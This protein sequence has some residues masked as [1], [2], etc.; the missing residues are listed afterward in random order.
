M[1]SRLVD[2]QLYSNWN[3]RKCNELSISINVNIIKTDIILS[4]SEFI[5]QQY[6]SS[7]AS[8][9]HATTIIV[10]GEF[11]VLVRIWKKKSKL[12]QCLRAKRVQIVFGFGC[13]VQPNSLS[14]LSL[15]LNRLSIE[16]QV[17]LSLNLLQFFLHRVGKTKSHFLTF[18][19]NM[20]FMGKGLIDTF[21]E[22]APKCTLIP[23]KWPCEHEFQ[24]QQFAKFVNSEMQQFIGVYS[25]GVGFSR[26]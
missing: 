3:N 6:T 22:I 1:E 18:V 13:A 9:T 21:F 4:S 20:I 8:N 19:F 10:V 25:I 16:P 5:H 24:K 11:C 7:C 14:S 17:P 15:S 23:G 2:V 26:L 12:D